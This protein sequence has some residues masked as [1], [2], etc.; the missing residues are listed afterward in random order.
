[1]AI[2]AA[3]TS[4]ATATVAAGC[5]LRSARVA[6]ILGLSCPC[7]GWPARN[8]TGAIARHL[9]SVQSLHRATIW[10]AAGCGGG[11]GCGCGCGC[12]CGGAPAYEGPG[13]VV[14]HAGCNCG[15]GYS[16]Y[17]QTP[18]QGVTQTAIKRRPS[19]ATQIATRRRRSIATRIKPPAMRIK[20]PCG[21]FPQLPAD[22]RPRVLSVT[23]HVVV[24]AD[25]R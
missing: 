5:W 3:A 18:P 8:C 4:A 20:T 19:M 22:G 21:G 12:G 24:P 10:A 15:N 9:Q 25:N 7:G 17:R 11:G 16:Y 23:D 14:P 13:Q 1:M 2:A 6:Q